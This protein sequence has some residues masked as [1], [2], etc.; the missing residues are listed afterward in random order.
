MASDSL[1]NSFLESIKRFVRE[2]KTEPDHIV[3]VVKQSGLIDEAGKASLD[4]QLKTFDKDIKK[5]M[6]GEMSYAEMRALYG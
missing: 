2:A 1:S 3:N 5:M 4:Q 6:K